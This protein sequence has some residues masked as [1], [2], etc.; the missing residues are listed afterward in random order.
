VYHRVSASVWGSLPGLAGAAIAHEEW[1]FWRNLP[2]GVLI[3]AL[4]LHLAV[5][6]AKA[7][8]RWRSGIAA[9]CVGR[10]RALAGLPLVLRIGEVAGAGAQRDVRRWRVEGRFWERP[11][12]APA[13]GQSAG[14]RANECLSWG[15]DRSPSQFPHQ[16]VAV[17]WA[18]SRPAR[19]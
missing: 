6:M 1:V 16:D 11:E 8:R 3:R 10:V 15:N 18:V 4:P 2:A 13:R 14:A 9:V 19:H 5:V 12:L 17:W 7:W